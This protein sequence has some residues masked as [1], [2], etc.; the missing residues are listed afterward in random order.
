MARTATLARLP[1]RLN[2]KF[3]EVGP[4]FA[5]QLF[6]RRFFPHAVHDLC[7]WRV[8][9]SDL[10]PFAGMAADNSGVR[11]AEPCDFDRIEC[12]EK[13]CNEPEDRY[14]RGDRLAI[15]EDGDEIVGQ[16]WFHSGPCDY[17]GWLRLVPLPS[18]IWGEQAWTRR[19]HRGR[20]IID[21][22]HA[23]AAKDHADRGYTR[24]VYC[25]DTLNRISVQVS[26]K[27]G[28]T[29]IGRIWYWRFLTFAFVRANGVLRFGRWTARNPVTV[30]LARLEGPD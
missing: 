24:M 1:R 3:H 4:L 30:P 19:S 23:F 12:F 20:R 17:D 11:W 10:R 9:A 28:D 16:I 7:A 18:D 27:R 29:P 21:R 8:F 26:E 6:L 25:T 15:F 22:I 5:I 13:S 14:A 2:R